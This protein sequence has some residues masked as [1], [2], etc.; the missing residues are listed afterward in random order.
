MKYS[1]KL[2]GK[3]GRHLIPL[4]LTSDDVDAMESE[5]DQYK[6]ALEY[7]AHAGL[8]A[9][10]CEDEARKAL[11]IVTPDPHEGHPEI[12]LDFS[13]PAYTP[14]R[15]LHAVCGTNPCTCENAPAV[16]RAGG[17]SSPDQETP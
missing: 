3:S 1:G 17:T 9:R 10:H 13:R 12:A 6:A 4:T 11:G 15:Y 16:P 5:R 7:I 14:P 8:S 2:Y